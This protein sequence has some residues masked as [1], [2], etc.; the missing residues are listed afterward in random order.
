MASLGT[1]D[2]CVCMIVKWGTGDKLCKHPAEINTRACSWYQNVSTCSVCSLFMNY[3][4]YTN[5][6]LMASAAIADHMAVTS[7]ELTLEARSNF[8]WLRSLLLASNSSSE[9]GH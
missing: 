7:C 1:G 5:L 9:W 8:H 4:V 6:I 3:S 2:V